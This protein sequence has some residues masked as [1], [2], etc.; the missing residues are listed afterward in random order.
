MASALS[1]TPNQDPDPDRFITA[2]RAGEL[3]V[4]PTDT[5][6]GVF[7]CAGTPGMDRLREFASGD[8]DTPLG[9]WHAPDVSTLFEALGWDTPPLLPESP[10]T[11][12]PWRRAR[13][14]MRL[15]AQATTVRL[16]CDD[17]ELANLHQYTSLAEGE[18]TADG[19]LLVRVPGVNAFSEVAR[20]CGRSA[21][22]GRAAPRADL[23]PSDWDKGPVLDAGR[24]PNTGPSS[25]VSLNREGGWSLLREGAAPERVLDRAMRVR[26][27]FVCT[28]NTCRSPMAEA[29]ARTM[30]PEEIDVSSAGAFASDGAPATAEAVNAARNFGADASQHR[31]RALQAEMIREA[32]AVFAMTPD[33]AEA[34]ISIAPDAAG[35]IL[36]L[37]PGGQG[38]PDPIGGPQDEYN[39]TAS[40]IEQ[41]VRE[42]LRGLL[43]P[44]RDRA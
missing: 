36:P 35:K 7:A 39:G 43:V 37:D 42:R 27:L 17:R 38:I 1:Q 15:L 18:A 19:A 30:L 2:L 5:V 9:A 12:R 22:V 29:I 3:A 21:L 34:A 44:A 28:G 23:A 24:L 40:R 8:Q 6:Y 32:D 20:G 4:L 26:L 25:R 14:A 33:H 10:E 11:V 41:L 31:S 13:N 16:E